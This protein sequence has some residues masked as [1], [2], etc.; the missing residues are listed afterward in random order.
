M[1]VNADKHKDFMERLGLWM[2]ISENLKKASF[3][4]VNCMHIHTIYIHILC[5]PVPRILKSN[6]LSW[7]KNIQVISTVI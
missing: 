5:I 7:K 6:L 2:K 4:L 1:E 3:F